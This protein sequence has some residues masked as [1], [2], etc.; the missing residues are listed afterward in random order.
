LVQGRYPIIAIAFGFVFLQAF[1]RK[2]P[3]QVALPF[4]WTLRW[5]ARIAGVAFFAAIA[6]IGRRGVFGA[7]SDKT[8]LNSAAKETVSLW[9]LL[10][11]FGSLIIRHGQIIKDGSWK[12]KQQEVV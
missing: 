6:G 2:V 8:Q 11:L 10:G 1:R 9:T 12:N 7:I 3:W 4:A 5:L